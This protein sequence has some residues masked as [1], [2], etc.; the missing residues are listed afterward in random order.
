MRLEVE[1]GTRHRIWSD[2]EL[3]GLADGDRIPV[4]AVLSGVGTG[5]FATFESSDGSYRASIPVEIVA[6]QGFLILEAETLR[7]RVV[8]GTTL[9]WNV[10]DVA[11]I[12]VTEGKLPDSVPE[13]PPH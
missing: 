13:N 2:E 6:R 4:G 3:A 11:R 5:G 12:L 10:K 7:L 8:D 9:C 1:A